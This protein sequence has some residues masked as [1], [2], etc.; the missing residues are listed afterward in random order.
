MN[1][2]VCAVFCTII[3]AAVPA[4]AGPI[5]ITQV[6]I[7]TYTLPGGAG[8]TGVWANT[9]SNASVGIT[10]TG[11]ATNPY[12]AWGSVPSSGS[13][14]LFLGWGDRFEYNTA[15]AG[16]LQ[17][18]LTVYY[19]N[20]T[21]LS[22]DFDNNVLTSASTWTEISGSPVISLGS[23][24]IT[25][26]N[27]NSGQGLWPTLQDDP[28]HPAIVLALSSTYVSE[29]SGIVTLIANLILCAGLLMVW[30]RFGN[31]HPLSH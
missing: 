26:S 6:S 12:L 18:D 24:G 2:L 4:W 25:D 29:P 13:Y 28:S 20:G 31:A 1:R 16:S 27:R 21:S 8:P 9:G 14:L 10:D 19:S 15:P 30:S 23:S 5:T 17:L 7:D 3:A 22:A 11:S